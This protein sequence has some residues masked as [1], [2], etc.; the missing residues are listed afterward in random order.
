M[1]KHNIGVPVFR[2]LRE[3]VSLILG[4]LLATQLVP[5]ISYSNNSTLA[6]VVIV[7][8]LLNALLR[9][10]LRSVLI[11]LSLPLVL[12]TFGLAAIFVLWIVNSILFYSAAVLVPTFR[13]ETFGDAMLGAL[14][15]SGTSWLLSLLLGDDSN[16]RKT[17]PSPGG[18][19]R[20]SQADDII[21]V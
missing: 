19:K 15:V 11:F 13:V 17:P 10:F 9:P 5:G 14:V 1:L 7:L 3:L 4:V 20:L 18:G 21:D 6:A 16:S 8:A 12:L 2:W